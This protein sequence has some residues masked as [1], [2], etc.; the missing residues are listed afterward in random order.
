M[1]ECKY[2]SQAVDDGPCDKIALT[3]RNVLECEFYSPKIKTC[4]KLPPEL[5]DGEHWTIAET[6]EAVLEAMKEWCNG[7]LKWNSDGESITI[8]VIEMTQAE[9]DA[10]PDI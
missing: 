6:T 1:T 2:C 10:L 3:R 4:F 8:E 9:I 7:C 5:A